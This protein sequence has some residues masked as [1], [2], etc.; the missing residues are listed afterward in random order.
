MLRQIVH[1]G[2]YDPFM[3]YDIQLHQPLPAMGYCT[4]HIHANRRGFNVGGTRAGRA[5]NRHG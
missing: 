1:Y 2:N 4:L 5:G 3:K